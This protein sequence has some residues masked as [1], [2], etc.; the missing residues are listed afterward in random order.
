[1][2]RF[3]SGGARPRP[4]SC[5]VPIPNCRDCRESVLTVTTGALS[6]AQD[7]SAPPKL[8]RE[9]R[10]GDTEP[11]LPLAERS[12]D[13]QTGYVGPLAPSGIS[14]ILALEIAARRASS[15]T[16]EPAY[17]NREYGAGESELG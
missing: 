17:T 12:G 15:A 13:C 3:P 5:T 9:I 10:L 7:P 6:G 1:M 4:D 11:I 8:R 14:S 16:Q 2:I